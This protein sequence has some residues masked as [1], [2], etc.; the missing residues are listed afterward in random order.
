VSLL[1]QFYEAT[2]NYTT[3]KQLYTFTK[4][5]FVQK[6]SELYKNL[7]SKIVEMDKKIAESTKK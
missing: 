5:N 2:A 6:D 4:E 1:G 7:D 3:A